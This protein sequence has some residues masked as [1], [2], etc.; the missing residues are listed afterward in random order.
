MKSQSDSPLKEYI[1]ISLMSIQKRLESV[2]E[3][4]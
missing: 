3:P 1:F 2:L 4:T